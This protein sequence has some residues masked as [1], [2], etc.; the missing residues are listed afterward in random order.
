MKV[1]KNLLVGLG[2]GLLAYYL[3]TRNKKKVE[4][5]AVEE[6]KGVG[7]AIPMPNIAP[8]TKDNVVLKN[9]ISSQS[10]TKEESDAIQKAIKLSGKIPYSGD[11]IVTSVGNFKYLVVRKGNRGIGSL[12][13]GTPDI[14]GWVRTTENPPAKQTLPKGITSLG[15]LIGK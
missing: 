10:L 7:G 12:S 1:N 5:P 3:Y 14:Y 6:P 9:P 2:I 15:Q 4:Q 13:L 11:I 8:T